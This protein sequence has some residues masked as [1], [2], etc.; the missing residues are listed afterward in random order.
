MV[1]I[2][3]TIHLLK[4]CKKNSKKVLTKKLNNG[5]VYLLAVNN[6]EC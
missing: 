2:D 5:I 6:T 4:K 3:Y 1:A